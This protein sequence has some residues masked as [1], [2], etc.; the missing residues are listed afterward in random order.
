MTQTNNQQTQASSQ[1]YRDDEIDL[2]KLLSI[3]WKGKWWII[4]VTFLFTVASVIYAL[5]LPNEYKAT[6][7]VQ[8]ND[9]GAGGKLA[10]LAGEF[11]GL[12]SLAGI[13]IGTGQSS[14]AVIAMEV[15]KSW[16]FAEGFIK[17]HDLA[18]PLFAAKD[19]KQ[20]T[21][22][23]VI[24]D[25]S[26]DV[27]QKKWI[28]EAPKGKT[29]EPTSW[30]LYKRFKERV[31]VSQDKE[32]GLVSVSVSHYSPIIA[33][34]WTDLLVQDINQYMK[35][36]ALDE[37]NQ[38]IEYLEQQINETSV[39]EIRTVFSELIQEQHKTKM[40]ANV[41]DE[42]VFRTLNR[43]K[44]PEEKVKP[45]R[46]IICVLGFLFGLILSALYILTKSF[47]TRSKG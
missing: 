16:G 8:P 2:R 12:A 13:N 19:W 1:N 40:L 39:A 5:S 14:D 31:A 25:E 41:S 23:L 45:N 7:V 26:Y 43:A 24:D 9:S 15:M 22:E 32:T 11:G 38:S 30:E 3:L 35:V 6:A 4:C 34:Q 42:F 10:S 17:R 33:K 20:P 37:A 36:R 28:R 21:N 27:S 44:A 47:I 46:A 18:V 29:V